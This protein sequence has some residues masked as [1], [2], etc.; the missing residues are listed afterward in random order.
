MLGSVQGMV[1]ESN[2][3]ALHSHGTSPQELI[4]SL[5][6]AGLAVYEVN[7]GELRPVGHPLV[8][9]ETIVD[10][11]AVRGAPPLPTGWT[12]CKPRSDGEIIDALIGE[13]MHA[14]P[15]HRDHALRTIDGLSRKLARRYRRTVATATAAAATGGGAAGG[16]A[17]GDR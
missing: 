6:A 14:I 10:Y 9:P 1:I 11:A 12:R 8:Q 5:E 17:A 3:Y 2:G 7:E 4:R 13:S 16:G 15:E